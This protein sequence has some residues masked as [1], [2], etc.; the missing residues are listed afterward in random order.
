MALTCLGL[1]LLFLL[2]YEIILSLTRTSMNSDILVWLFTRF[3][4]EI[5]GLTALQ[6]NGIVSMPSFDCLVLSRNQA[7]FK[8]MLFYAT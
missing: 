6:I 1:L 8:L 4:I 5:W 7:T 3:I 2:C